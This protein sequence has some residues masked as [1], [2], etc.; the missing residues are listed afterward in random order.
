MLE[1]LLEKLGLSEKEAKVY[2]ATLELGQDTVQHIAKKASVVR[3]TTYVILEKLMSLGL[4]STVEEGKKTLFIAESPKELAN[5]LSQ[6]QQSI[7]ARKQELDDSLNQLMAIYNASGDKP[8][9]RY[10]EGAEGLVALDKYGQEKKVKEGKNEIF[11]IFPLDILE[12]QFPERRKEAV[13]S[14]VKAGIH[15][16][17]IYTRDGGP[18]DEE[19]NK[20][21]NREALYLPRTVLPIDMTL[22]VFPWGV[23]IFYLDEHKPYGILIE[24][25]AIARNMRVMLEFAW[26]GAKHHS[27]VKRS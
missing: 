11:S 6:Q 24:N 16:R 18:V 27:E 26:L 20:Q 17:A 8:T 5:L 12:R 7:E 23:K 25:E 13:T 1:K 22:T 15:S 2:L 9:V 21:E 10:F 14:R 19:R 4:V 3:P